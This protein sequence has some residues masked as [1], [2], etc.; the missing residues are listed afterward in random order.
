MNQSLVRLNKEYKQYLKEPNQYYSLYPDPNNFYIWNVL[1]IGPQETIF[2]G[3]IFECKIKFPNDYP[4]KPPEFK[5]I[6]NLPHPNIY[7]DGKVCISILRTGTDE[8]NYEHIS[9]RWNP[10]H[11][12]NSII[13][14]IL[15]MLSEP[16]LESPADI[17]I[18]KLWRDNFY[19]Y[20]KMI[21]S[22]ISN[23]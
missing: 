7:T 8:F 10:S 11:S 1:L 19:E 9:E 21:Y 17:D 14:S 5:F 18:A 3:G 20:K 15:N 22:I 16:N 2:E 4:N 23:N 13:I 6:T 12:V